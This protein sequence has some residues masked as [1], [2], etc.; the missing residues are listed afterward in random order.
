MGESTKY[1]F[2]EAELPSQIDTAAPIL[3]HSQIRPTGGGVK[4]ALAPRDEP[5]LF[6]KNARV[7]LKWDQAEERS[8]SA[9]ETAT[10]MD[11]RY[12]YPF[13]I[14]SGGSY[15][16]RLQ[17]ENI[18][19]AIRAGASIQN[20]IGALSQILVPT[21]ANAEIGVPFGGRQVR[22]GL[23]ENVQFLVNEIC[24]FAHARI[25]DDVNAPGADWKWTRLVSCLFLYADEDIQDALF[26]RAMDAD[27]P[28]MGGP[29][30]IP[31]SQ[32]FY[33]FGRTC[34]NAEHLERF[35]RQTLAEWDSLERAPWVV[36][37]PFQKCLGNYGEPARVPSDL[38]ASV[39]RCAVEL[40]DRIIEGRLP[41]PQV[42][43]M[44][45]WKKWTLSAILFGLRRRELDSKFMDLDSG[46]SLAA[47]VRARL[48][49]SEI[50]NTPIPPIALAGIEIP[51][52]PPTLPE[53]ILRF[54]EARADETDIA[55]AGGIGLTS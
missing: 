39:M 55:I 5:D 9:I 52:H 54:L 42:F 29:A 13:I 12:S 6:G 4:I 3:I 11:H 20:Y 37:W 30:A 48:L 32:A 24:R 18:S 36:F 19:S 51:G 22:E 53:L 26:D 25:T 46:D 45:N 10:S 28:V 33:A 40:L 7:A 21:L 16:S 50:F 23:S 47:D 2:V 34:R 17:L 15:D 27:Y 35:L 41:A 44:S 14:Q 43:G 1:R 38:V 8:V 49:R 31:L